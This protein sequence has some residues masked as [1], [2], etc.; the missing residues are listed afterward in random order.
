MSDEVMIGDQPLPYTV[1]AVTPNLSGRRCSKDD[2]PTY[3]ARL[4]FEHRAARL[5][6]LERYRHGLA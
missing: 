3:A 6:Y 2:L 1:A 5:R 4:P